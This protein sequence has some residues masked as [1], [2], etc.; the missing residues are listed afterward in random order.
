MYLA[1]NVLGNPVVDRCIWI[2]YTT[3]F[4]LSVV[5]NIVLKFKKIINKQIEWWTGTNWCILLL[6]QEIVT[7]SPQSCVESSQAPLA[8]TDEPFALRGGASIGIIIEPEFISQLYGFT[9]DSGL[10]KNAVVGYS[11]S[12]NN[13]FFPKKLCVSPVVGEVKRRLNVC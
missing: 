9:L 6:C 2:L 13:G 3:V 1:I 5:L 8:C 7:F 4:Q 11:R 12:P 10:Y